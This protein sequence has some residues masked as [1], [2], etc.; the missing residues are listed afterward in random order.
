MIRRCASAVECSRSIASGREVDCGIE[1]ETARRPD[2]VV[3]NRL[4]DTHERYAHLVELV[5]M[6]SVPS[7]P[8]HTSASSDI[9]PNISKTRSA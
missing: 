3:V 8:M 9:L 6:A 4:R 2:D 1:P 7:P 5:E